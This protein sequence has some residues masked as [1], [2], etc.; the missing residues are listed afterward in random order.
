MNE[1]F[2]LALDAWGK[3]SSG[4]MAGN[5]YW[6]GSAYECGHYLR[7]LNNTVLEQPFQTRT[8]VIGSAFGNP[9]GILY[10]VC[11][12]QSCSPTDILNY[13]NQSM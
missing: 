4:L 1:S 11:V 13:I 7:G 3:F 6:L 8:C 2:I 9:T 10:G 5:R 12:P